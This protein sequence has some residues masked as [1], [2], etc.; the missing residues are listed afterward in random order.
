MSQDGRLLGL[1]RRV[2]LAIAAVLAAAV[3]S[4][5]TPPPDAVGAEGGARL[6]S[7]LTAGAIV[8]LAILPFVVWRRAS[9]PAIWV[10]TTIAALALGMTAFSAGWYG[11]RACTATYNSHS[12][13]IGTELTPLGAAYA[14]EN[15]GLSSDELL[16]DAAGAPERIWTR[17]SIDRCRVFVG[18]TYALWIPFLVI[19]LVAAAQAVPTTVLA[20]VRWDTP[21][22]PVP[23]DR[24]LRYDVFMSYRHD[25]VDRTFARELA[26]ALEDAGYRVAIDE[27]DFTA[28]ASFLQEMERAVRESRFTVAILSPRYLQSGNTEEEAIIAKVLDMGDRRRRLIPLIVEPVAMPAWLYGIVGIDWTRHDPLVDPFDKLKTTLGTPLAASKDLIPPNA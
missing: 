18:S 1:R 15:A 14:Q 24:P 21:D 11:R 23:A 26:S 25:G 28:N 12:V 7:A 16:F 8:T 19:C 10:A 2:W 9:R 6:F 17:S 13:V 4:A 20:P 3:A 22:L 27:R 5:L